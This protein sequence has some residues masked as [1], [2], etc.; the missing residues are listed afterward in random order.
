MARVVDDQATQRLKD[1]ADAEVAAAKERH[2]SRST[3]T[4]SFA[5]AE[6]KLTQAAS[7]WEAAQGEAVTA[8]AAAVTALIDSGM[9]PGDVAELLGIPAKQVR[10]LRA[11]APCNAETNEASDG[12]STNG[13]TP[14][15]P[16]VSQPTVP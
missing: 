5:A 6:V 1:L 8:K 2:R 10:S 15:S 4:A 9:K 13:Q 16:T 3:A 11:S 14:H 12:G 7:A